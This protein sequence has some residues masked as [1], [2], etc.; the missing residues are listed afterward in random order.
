MREKIGKRWIYWFTLAVAVMIAYKALDIF[1]NLSLW[2]QKFFSILMPFFVGTIIAYLLYIPS[3]RIEKLYK[4][5]KFLKKKARGLAVITIYVIAIIIITLVIKIIIPTLSESISDLASNL[6]G[7]FEK[8]MG[9]INSISED[10]IIKKESILEIVSGLQKIDITKI[11]NLDN[12]WDYING[13][14]G[15]ASGIFSVFVTIIMSVYILLERGEIVQFVRRLN[16][17]LFKEET[18]IKIDKYFIKANNIFFKFISSQIIDA[19]IVGIIVSIALCILK[20]KYW[21]LLGFMIGLF[22]IIPY[23]GAIVAIVIAA[24]VTLL[25]GGLTKTIWM[26]ITVVVLQQIDANIINPRIIKNAL[27]L[28]PILV[29][30]SVTLLGA[31]F[32]VLGMF[33]AVPIVALIKILINDFIDYRITRSN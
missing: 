23:F 16:K 9:Y 33:L 32:G 1:A 20:V 30:F 29:I 8:A 26:V 31:Y 27:K 25:T 17:A 12:V 3:R 11:I 6:P 24:I 14:L 15:F 10:S 5:V 28:S 18:C 4:R 7:Y 22:N 19:V 13:V 21:V 2:L